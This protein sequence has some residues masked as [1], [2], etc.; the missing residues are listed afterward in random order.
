MFHQVVVARTTD[1][2]T[3]SDPRIVQPSASVPDGVRAPDGRTLV[4]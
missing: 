3:L 4:D 1:G 2:L